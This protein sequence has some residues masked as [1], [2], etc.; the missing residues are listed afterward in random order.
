MHHDGTC[1]VAQL[2]VADGSTNFLFAHRSPCVSRSPSLFYFSRRH[3]TE[4]IF[5]ARI[6]CLRVKC[7]HFHYIFWARLNLAETEELKKRR[8]FARVCTDSLCCLL[9]YVCK[10]ILRWL[11]GVIVKFYNRHMCTATIAPIT[12]TANAN[13]SAK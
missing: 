3:H 4:T 13:F 2:L 6:L 12:P 9:F 7:S 5:S 10:K 11:N 8:L 1:P